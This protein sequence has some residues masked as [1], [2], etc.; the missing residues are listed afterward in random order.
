MQAVF[1]WRLLSISSYSPDHNKIFTTE[2]PRRASSHFSGLLPLDTLLYFT[3][4]FFIF[5]HS[6][7]TLSFSLSFFS[8][9]LFYLPPLTWEK[10]ISLSLS[11]SLSSSLSFSRLSLSLSHVRSSAWYKKCISLSFFLSFCLSLS[12]S[13]ASSP[14]PFS[15]IS[16][17]C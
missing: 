17:N 14:F 6:S 1:A 5:G 15:L 2:V 16:C 12:L 4:V 3:Y 9:S 8:F 13:F 7:L 10:K 11:L